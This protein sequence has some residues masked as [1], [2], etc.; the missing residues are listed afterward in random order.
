MVLG[1][2]SGQT[3]IGNTIKSCNL[4]FMYFFWG[5]KD[6]H[7]FFD[8]MPKCFFFILKILVLIYAVG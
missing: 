6:Y 3:G 7:K 5:G 1:L 4:S 8:F 2:K